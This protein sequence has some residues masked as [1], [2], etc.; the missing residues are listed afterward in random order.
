[1]DEEMDNYFYNPFDQTKIIQVGQCLPESCSPTNVETILKLDPGF[2]KF[3]EL[4]VDEVS[5]DLKS[6]GTI[7]MVA[8]RTVPGSYDLWTD[9]RFQVLG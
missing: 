4:E 1:M 6:K 5:A 8:S 9:K 2:V 3:N 7:T